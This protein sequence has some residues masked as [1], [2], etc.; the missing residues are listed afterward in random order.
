LRLAYIADLDENQ[1]F[2]LFTTTP[3]GNTNVVRISNTGA[4]V[5]GFNTGIPWKNKRESFAWSPD[6]SKIA[7]RADHDGVGKCKFYVADTAT[8]GVAVLISSDSAETVHEFAWAPNSSR[9]AYTALYTDNT[10]GLNTV[11]PDGQGQKMVS[12]KFQH[13]GIPNIGYFAWA[14][15]SSRLAYSADLNINERY[16]LFTTLPDTNTTIT[17]PPIS[18]VTYYD[19]LLSRGKYREFFWSPD[20]NYIAYLSYQQVENVRQLFASKADGSS[21]VKLSGPL[22]SSKDV[23]KFSW[24]PDSSHV[25]YIADQNS[26]G[27]DELFA[28]PIAGARETTESDGGGP[29]S[30]PR[31]NPDLVTNG[32]VDPG[33]LQWSEDSQRVFYY[34]DQEIENEKEFYSSTRD[35]S[36]NNVRI[37][38]PIAVSFANH[39]Y[40]ILNNECSGCHM[41]GEAYPWYADNASDT[42][43]NMNAENYFAANFIVEKIDGT[44][45]HNGGTF[46]A[47]ASLFSRWISEGANNN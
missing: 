31:L 38:A 11:Q 33:Y 30:N 8:S 35:G 46:A 22:S 12:G 5:T 23:W 24:S 20:S 19:G 42:Y 32:D 9:I 39:I 28:S 43:D 10:I 45:S 41:P 4:P 14:P 40:P 21:N 15:D 44:L 13:S 17:P 34:A 37:S 27:T 26:D 6:S 36:A 25:A 29:A 7:Y 18:G 47:T 1:V 2:E 16:E 3:D